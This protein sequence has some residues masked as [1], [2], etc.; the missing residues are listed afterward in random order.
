MHPQV[1]LQFIGPGADI[2]PA[3][4]IIVPGSKSV[5]ADLVW[6]KTNGW[7]KVIER[8][9]RYGGKVLG[10]CGGYQ[11]LGTKI[12]GLTLKNDACTPLIELDN[13][14]ADGC[15][16]ADGQVAGT[17]LHG[18][19]DHPE[20]GKSLLEWAGLEKPASI[21]RAQLREREIN[22]LTDCVEQHMNL[23]ALFPRWYKE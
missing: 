5:R 19:F 8:H 3:D 2:P 21:D 6:L 16:S 14:T 1:D 7:D 4:L 20:A 9:L 23:A 18:L 11:M 12:S 10:I 17:Y 13:G 22:R 15:L